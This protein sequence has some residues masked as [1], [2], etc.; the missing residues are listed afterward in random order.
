MGL[1]AGV[2]LEA[3]KC[4]FELREASFERQNPQSARLVGFRDSRLVTRL[5]GLFAPPVA[6]LQHDLGIGALEGNRLQ[7]YPKGHRE[8]PQDALTAV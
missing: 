1:A 3:R 4:R 7:A 6:L 8:L 2:P 5:Q